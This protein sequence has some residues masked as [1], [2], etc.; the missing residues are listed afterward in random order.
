MLEISATDWLR[1]MRELDGLGNS[2]NVDLVKAISAG[3]RGFVTDPLRRVCNMCIDLNL[4]LSAAYAER[5]IF[6]IEESP[7]LQ[8]VIA[9]GRVEY[10]PIRSMDVVDR[11]GVLRERIDD[12]I[13]ELKFYIIDPGQQQF[14]V[15]CYGFGEGVL[16]AF[17]SASTDIEEAAKCFALGRYTASVFH[18]MR[19]AEHG[20][21]AMTSELSVDMNGYKQWHNLIDEVE[22][23]IKKFDMQPGRPPDWRDRR[24]FLSGAAIHFRHIKNGWRNHV[25]HTRHDHSAESAYGIYRSISEFMSHLATRLTEE[26]ARGIQSDS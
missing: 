24:D 21:R 12:E 23:A 4:N 17:P 16:R 8:E 18:L 3:D 26:G 1:I 9:A 2:L 25:S 7:S 14:L 6:E 11:I 13:R 22:A 10:G 5:L 15:D 20:L 19:V